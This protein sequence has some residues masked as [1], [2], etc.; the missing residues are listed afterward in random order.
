MKLLFVAISLAFIF[1]TCDS[2][3]II[4]PEALIGRWNP[5]YQ[6][7]TKNADG[8]WGPWATIN[9]LVALPSMEFT[10]HGDFLRDGKP[11]ADCCSAGNKFTVANNIIT[12][13]DLKSCP[14][15]KCMD[16]SKWTINQVDSDTLVIEVCDSR[17]KF[18]RDK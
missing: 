9:T 10:S 4:K 13:S 2:K 6:L 7:Q 18:S 11:G 12:F 5:S 14:Q 1:D 3:K 8:S 16:C 17:S 15:V